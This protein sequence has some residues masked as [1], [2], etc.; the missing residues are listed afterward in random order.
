MS[1]VYI[2]LAAHSGSSWGKSLAPGGFITAPGS[3]EAPG[4]RLVHSLSPDLC[5]PASHSP[6]ARP[7]FR[8]LPSVGTSFYQVWNNH[9][10]IRLLVLL[11]E[12]PSPSMATISNSALT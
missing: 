12:M 8:Q 10:S 3:E 7:G 11:T 1:Q 5:A 4:W 2:L 6:Q 9:T